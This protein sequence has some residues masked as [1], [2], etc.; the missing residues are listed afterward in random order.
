MAEPSVVVY[1]HPD[2]DYSVTLKSDLDKKGVQYREIDISTVPGATEELMRLTNG[3]RIT[4]V[5]VEGGR[6]TVGYYGVG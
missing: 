2:C 5:M 3:E 6:V 4:P 1:T